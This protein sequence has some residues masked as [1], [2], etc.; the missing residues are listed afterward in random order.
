MARQN[1]VAIH[2]LD[3]GP[4]ADGFLAPASENATDDFALAVE[5]PFNSSFRLAREFKVIEHARH[6]LS[7]G[8]NRLLI[9]LGG[10]GLSHILSRGLLFVS[11]R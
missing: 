7:A 5:D 1:H 8:G 10:S 9:V 3:R 2:K 6:S 11:Y 4:Y